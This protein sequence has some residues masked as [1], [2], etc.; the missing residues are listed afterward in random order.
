MNHAKKR[1]IILKIIPANSYVY[2]V[3]GKAVGLKILLKYKS[4]LKGGKLH[5]H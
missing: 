2:T 1:I 5:E 4:Y 3:C